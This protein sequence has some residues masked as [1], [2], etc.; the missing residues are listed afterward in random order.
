M[1]QDAATFQATTFTHPTVGLIMVTVL[2]N[3][4]MKPPRSSQR[5]YLW[6]LARS[7]TQ[8]RLTRSQPSSITSEM[9]LAPQQNAKFDFFRASDMHE[10]DMFVKA[11]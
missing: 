10:C 6:A 8:A 9:S 5:E 7:A 3:T 2:P 4:L 11:C 1:E